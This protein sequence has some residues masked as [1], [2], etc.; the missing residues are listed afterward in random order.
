M[1]LHPYLLTC[2]FSF[3]SVLCYNGK[4][5]RKW[6]VTHTSE[7][8]DTHSVHP[9]G[10]W[11]WDRERVNRVTQSSECWTVIHAEWLNTADNR[12]LS[13][14]FCFLSRLSQTK[15]MF[16]IIRVSNLNKNTLLICWILFNYFLNIRTPPP[17][18]PATILSLL[19]RCFKKHPTLILQ[20]CNSS[21][22]RLLQSDLLLCFC[23]LLQHKLLC[24]LKS[25]ISHSQVHA[26]RDFMLL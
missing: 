22:H 7:H 23:F 18:P 11:D 21:H 12:S 6:T 26:H 15:R 10:K 3:L 1:G 16:N 20:S 19:Q 4:N 14:R 24:R 17:Y 13:H 5:N 8:T 25:A 9:P 2:L